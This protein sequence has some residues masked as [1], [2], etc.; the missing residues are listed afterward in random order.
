[1]AFGQIWGFDP[2]VR[3]KGNVVGKSTIR[4]RITSTP[5]GSS[6][7]FPVGFWP[8]SGQLPTIAS[9]R[10]ER[11]LFNVSTNNWLKGATQGGSKLD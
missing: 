4:V 10:P 9:Q 3:E 2:E 5:F 8:S 11:A 1:M 6:L 7:A